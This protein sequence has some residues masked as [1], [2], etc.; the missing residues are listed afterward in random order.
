MSQGLA[1]SWM[2]TFPMGVR[3][4]G[5]A[6]TQAFEKAALRLGCGSPSPGSTLSAEEDT[7]PKSGPRVYSPQ[8]VICVRLALCGAALLRVSL[9]SSDLLP[10]CWGLSALALY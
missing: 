2:G 4:P 9:D 7:L 6:F 1:E 5:T 3:V 10:P 8:Q